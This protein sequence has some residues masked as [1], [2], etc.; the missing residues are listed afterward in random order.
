MGLVRQV[1]HGISTAQLLSCGAAYVVGKYVFSRLTM[2]HLHTFN[3]FEFCRH[4]D[5]KIIISEVQDF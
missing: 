4:T 3:I 5:K 1:G 2:Y